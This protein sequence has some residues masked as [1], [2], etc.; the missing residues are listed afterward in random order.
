MIQFK[1]NLQFS[2]SSSYPSPFGTFP[3]WLSQSVSQ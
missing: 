1:N 3:L 2:N